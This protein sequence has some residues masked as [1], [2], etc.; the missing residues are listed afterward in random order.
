MLLASL[1]EPIGRLVSTSPSIEVSMFFIFPLSTDAPVY[2]WPFATV[3]LIVINVLAFFATATGEFFPIVIGDSAEPWL[4]QH[5]T[6]LQPLQWVTSIFLHGDL[7]H[8]LFNMLFL[9]VF[10]L[11]VEGKLGWWRFL[12]VY[13][14]IGVG[15]SAIEQALSILIGKEGASLGASSAIYG[16]MAISLVWAPM[17]VIQI[18][19]FAW[20]LLFVRTGIFEWTIRTVAAVYFAFDLLDVVLSATSG[21]FQFTTGA[22]HLMGAIGGLGIGV[23]LLKYEQVDCEGWDAFSV[24]RGKHNESLALDELRSTGPRDAALPKISQ[25]DRIEMATARLTHL[26]H[27]NQIDAAAELVSSSAIRLP[28]WH[29]PRQQLLHLIRE[30]Q[31]RKKWSESVPLMVRLLYLYGEQDVRVRLTLAQVLIQVEGRPQQALRVLSKLPPQ[32]LPEPLEKTRRQLIARAKQLSQEG[33]ME[34]ETQDW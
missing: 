27:E 20:I 9:W 31:R 28:A 18:F 3:A 24:W 22:L 13:L 30:L 11:V 25:Q 7:T 14:G 1:N 5:A 16:L 33:Q 32:P 4:L 8:L 17:N 6:G 2:H 23:A 15:Q 26:I 12:I 19:V 10:G 29:P 34:L 21:S